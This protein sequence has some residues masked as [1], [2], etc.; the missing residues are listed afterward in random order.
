VCSLA[1]LIY[2]EVARPVESLPRVCD[3]A[4]S[5]SAR[6]Q[7]GSLFAVESVKLRPFPPRAG[8]G[9]SSQ[10]FEFE[11]MSRRTGIR[12]GDPGFWGCNFCYIQAVCRGSVSWFVAVMLA[13]PDLKTRGL[14][15]RLQVIWR[16]VCCI[17]GTNTNFASH[18]LAA[19]D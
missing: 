13:L 14:P 11:R 18:L 1:S 16:G 5:T 6:R 3:M 17:Q 15:I 4:I 8:G 10:G 2:Y 7:N 12:G 9:Y 19:T